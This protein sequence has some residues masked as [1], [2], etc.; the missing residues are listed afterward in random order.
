LGLG[1]PVRIVTADLPGHLPWVRRPPETPRA[2]T[3]EGVVPYPPAMS[4]S[5][6][7]LALAGILRRMLHPA[8]STEAEAEAHLIELGEA[9]RAAAELARAEP[10]CRRWADELLRAV[11]PL[12]AS[13]PRPPTGARDDHER[14]LFRFVAEDLSSGWA[15]D[16]SAEFAYRTRLLGEDAFAALAACARSE[17][18]LLA[19]NAVALLARMGTPQARAVLMEVL[20]GARDPVVWFRCVRALGESGHV[21]AA[22]ELRRMLDGEADP[23]RRAALLYAL[24]RIGDPEATQWLMEWIEANRTD[25]EFLWSALPAL[26]RCGWPDE[27]SRRSLTERLRRLGR[28]VMRNAGEW[29]ESP[30]LDGGPG[31]PEDL[32]ALIIAEMAALATARFGADRERRAIMDVFRERQFYGPVHYLLVDVLASFGEEGQAALEEIVRDDRF[33]PLVR[34]HALMMLPQSRAI[35][36]ARA[37]V[38]A[39][40]LM[41]RAAPLMLRAAA[42]EILSGSR[43]ESAERWAR[44]ALM[45]RADA[46]AAPRSY[47]EEAELFLA[48]RTL[49]EMGRSD[50]ALLA[51]IAA[52][53]RGAQRRRDVRERI[54]RTLDA[55][56]EAVRR[57]D[58]QEER[59]RLE[60]LLDVMPQV[61]PENRDSWREYLR[62]YVEGL[63]GRMGEDANEYA[64]TVRLALRAAVAGDD[65]LTGASS[66]D[67]PWL[68][69]VLLELGRTRDP[70]AVE[71]LGTFVEPGR[72]A[73]AEACLALGATGRRE[74]VPHLLRALAG[75]DGFVRYCAYLALRA[76]T[77]RDHFAD[78]IYGNASER[79]RA[80]EAYRS[81]AGAER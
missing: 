29:R 52:I 17:H 62:R 10:A 23:A 26:A 80:V 9:T 77:G 2:P 42:L 69:E 36:V 71:A 1:D 74:A 3:G 48:V 47:E 8:L 14:M 55:Y 27:R 32:K 39:A 30:L 46:G 33:D 53:G 24:G 31:D 63:R 45:R 19:R 43:D 34:R 25:A 40:P 67:V 12:P 59:R 64:E 5:L 73:R 51:R 41:L 68:A 50:A 61:A 49:A 13:R 56:I 4:A 15:Y 16:P 70:A 79:A 60:E 38:E 35:G 6:R 76:I 58:A 28:V 7:W 81:E 18:P 54:L 57:S 78:W 20:R 66:P 22:R 21:P 72:P 65:P 44:G 37:C 11:P 75:D